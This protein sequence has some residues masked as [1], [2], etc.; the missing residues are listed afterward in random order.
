[1]EVVLAVIIIATGAAALLPQTRVIIAKA[2][3]VEAITL[4]RPGMI[5]IVEHYAETGRPLET[6]AAGGARSVRVSDAPEYEKHLSAARAFAAVAAASGQE[7]PKSGP[8]GDDSPYVLRAGVRDG[9]VVV[10]GRMAELARPFRFAFFPAVSESGDTMQWLC[11]APAPVGTAMLG[12]VF[13]TDISH[14][15][16]PQTCRG[17]PPR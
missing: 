1:V 10:M 13:S 9:A 6:E 16:L 7:A 4:A 8:R 11:G 5:M 14:D 2:R 3:M 17:V 12:K 15:L